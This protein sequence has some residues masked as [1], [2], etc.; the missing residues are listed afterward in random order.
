MYLKDSTFSDYLKYLEINGSSRVT[1]LHSTGS[2]ES[3]NPDY[4][5]DLEFQKLRIGH[6]KRSTGLKS[7]FQRFFPNHP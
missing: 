1:L 3:E 2:N 7:V 6:G 5:L 4:D